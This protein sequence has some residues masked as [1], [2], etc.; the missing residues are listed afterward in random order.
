MQNVI[1]PTLNFL[2]SL[3]RLPKIGIDSR[4]REVFLLG[5]ESK[6]KLYDVLEKYYSDQFFSVIAVIM[7]IDH[8]SHLS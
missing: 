2:Y 8:F 3:M 7:H 4:Y 5:V 6:F 1:P